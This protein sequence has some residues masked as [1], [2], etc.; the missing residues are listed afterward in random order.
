MSCVETF[1][2]AAKEFVLDDCKVWLLSSI[3]LLAKQFDK[4]FSISFQQQLLPPTHD[5]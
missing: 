2:V 3:D 4:T 1:L 5:S